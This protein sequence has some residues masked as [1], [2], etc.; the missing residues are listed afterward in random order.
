MPSSILEGS[1]DLSLKWIEHNGWESYDPYDVLGLPFLLR[2]QRLRRRSKV[3]NLSL[4]PLVFLALIFPNFFRR[5]FKVKRSKDAMVAALLAK[6]FLNLYQLTGEVR[7]LENCETLLEWLLDNSVKWDRGIG[8]GY[9]FDWESAVVM[10]PA[11]TPISVV[12]SIVARSFISAYESTRR[13]EYLEVL[14][15]VMKFFSNDLNK[16][17][18]ESGVCF[19]YTPIDD[20]MVHNANLM[21][22][23]VLMKLSS[24]LKV[25]RVRKLSIKAV[26]FTVSDQNSDG[27]FYYFF[28]EYARRRALRNV[29]D[30]FHTGYVIYSLC[31]IY[32]C[33]KN[34][35]LRESLVRAR[36][37]YLTRLF[38]GVV[39]ITKY[40]SSRF[41]GN[42]ILCHDCS[43]GILTTLELV[44]LGLADPELAVGMALWA[45]RCF[46][47]PSG[48]FYYSLNVNGVGLVKENYIRWGLAWMLL[49]LTELSMY[50]KGLKTRDY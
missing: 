8:W 12:T 13:R 6:S 27:S 50:F 28:K 30:N 43:Q 2:V 38:K 46:Q 17:K 19:S 26:R 22:A 4:S 18:L 15:E 23:E 39:P 34:G 29:I 35:W 10:I 31:K 40:P 45:I 32:K 14:G 42:R 25:K 9:N 24:I 44:S 11:K 37:F 21:T 5:V 1:L 7:F 48:Y 47:D 41:I 3:L 20:M 36:D 16:F 49:A 33:G